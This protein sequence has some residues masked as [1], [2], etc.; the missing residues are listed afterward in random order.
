[1]GVVSIGLDVGQVH[2]PTA[3]A[4]CELEKRVL[5]RG[6]WVLPKARGHT[7]VIDGSDVN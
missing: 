3:I 6:R 7:D 1:M 5:E 4:V 2:D